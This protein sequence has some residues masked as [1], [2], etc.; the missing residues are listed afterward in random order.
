MG[1]FSEVQV[2]WIVLD[3]ATDLPV[4][5]DTDFEYVT[6]NVSFAD[7]QQEAA[8]VITPA[9]DNI[10]EYSEYFIIQLTNITGAIDLHFFVPP[11]SNSP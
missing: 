6:G 9:T 10:P 2:H 5:N 4:P 7:K 11:E 3:A 1:I 8:L